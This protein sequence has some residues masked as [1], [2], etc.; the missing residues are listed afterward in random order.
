MRSMSF[1]VGHLQMSRERR[2]LRETENKNVRAYLV[3]FSSE[4]EIENSW[5]PLNRK[6]AYRRLASSQSMKLKRA[7]SFS[8]FYFFLGAYIAENACVVQQD[9]RQNSP[10]QHIHID[11][12][13]PIVTTYDWAK[14]ERRS[15]VWANGM[16]SKVIGVL[17]L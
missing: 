6:Q 11:Y 2:K 4:Q 10:C 9:D 14:T 8:Y 16:A 1:D 5:C 17:V 3:S 15:A 13:L 7:Q 12:V